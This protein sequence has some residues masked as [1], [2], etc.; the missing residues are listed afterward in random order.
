MRVSQSVILQI[1]EDADGEEKDFYVE[2]S[3]N[4]IVTDGLNTYTA[5]RFVA[6]GDT[7]LIALPFGT[8]AGVRGF[9]VEANG[10]FE[11]VLDKSS[12]SD[13]YALQVMP[14]AV[15]AKA[16]VAINAV[17]AA[18]HVRAMDNTP[19]SGRFVIYGELGD[20]QG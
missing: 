10:P 9:Y 5:G 4:P 7:S 12:A 13:G 3:V 2:K 1:S 14:L 11:L 15:G 20:L 17:V 16:I 6:P 18:L 19:V 8:V